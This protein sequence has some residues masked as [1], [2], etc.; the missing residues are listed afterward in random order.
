MID[1]SKY[2]NGYQTPESCWARFGPYYAMFPLDFAF[3]VVNTYSKIGDYIIDP[4]AGRGS[5]IYAGSVLGRKSLG[6]EINPL[7]W[8]YGFVK[9][10]PA[11]KENVVKRLNEIYEESSSY[12]M[13]VK[14]YDDFFRMC[15][16]D[17]VLSFLLAA[18]DNL[19]WR[20]SK[21]DRTLMAFIAVYMHAGLGEGLSN[22][23]RLTK[24]LGKQYSINWWEKNNL[25]TPPD[26]NPHD[27]ILQKI[28]HRY[29]K[30]LPGTTESNIKLG[31]SINITNKLIKESN[32]K[33][34][35][36]SLLFT[37]P[38]YYSITNYYA[39]QWLRLW[40]L[41][42]ADKPEAQND[43]HKRRF[44]NKQEYIDLLDS[45]FGNCALMMKE[46][47]T[48]YVRTDG[49]DFTR[50]TTLDILRKKFPDHAVRVIDKPVGKNI[51]TQTT[52]CGNSSLKPG[53]IDII[54]TKK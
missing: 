5:S 12:R 7:G 28:N 32:A 13:K 18:R 14:N 49:R 51:R 25:E 47:S 54:L 36:Y 39:D 31:D 3:D 20:H 17:T 41:G 42:G 19:D 50:N 8:L 23:M 43:K 16:S 22:Q 48:I 27:V 24:S 37:S 45:V 26:I 10:H 33:M 38:P 44:S 53:E 34:I 46:N 6:I 15:Y 11:K 4:F 1:C 40:L 9:L 52:I 35:K 21:V 29:Q 30:G 2:Y